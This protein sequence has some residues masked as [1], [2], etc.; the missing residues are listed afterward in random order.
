MKNKATKQKKKKTNKIPETKR[1]KS[2]WE[3]QE[4]GFSSLQWKS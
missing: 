3:N 1:V 2:A 4:K